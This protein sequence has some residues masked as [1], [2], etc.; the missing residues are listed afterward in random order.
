[1]DCGNLSEERRKELQVSFTSVEFAVKNDSFSS[2]L[3]FDTHQIYI[4]LH[5][6]Q[7]MTIGMICF[8]ILSVIFVNGGHTQL[9]K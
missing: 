8:M 1:M 5:F 4:F 9:A 2:G 7:R 6:I 3:N